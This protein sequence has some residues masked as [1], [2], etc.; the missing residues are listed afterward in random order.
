MPCKIVPAID[1]IDGKCVRL[2]QGSFD[3]VDVVGNDPLE[4]ARSFAA[5]GFSRLH[6]VDLSGA[7]AGSPQHLDVVRTVASQT[8][9]S[10]DYSG[11]LRTNTDIAA[12]LESGAK[13]IVI[14]S[15]AVLSPVLVEEALRSF[16]PDR[17][18]IGLD[19][20][21]GEV[22]IKGW[23]EGSELSLDSVVE[24]YLPCGLKRLMSTS[25]SRDGMLEGPDCEL[26]A[27]LRRRYPTLSLTASGGV[28]QAQDVERLAQLGV[29]EV[30]V[31][32][33]LYSGR[34]TLAE[35]AHYVW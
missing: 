5:Q 31:G 3:A 14:G 29:D 15:A 4:V 6:L 2:K 25:I 27:G 26:Y 23:E 30:I 21:G 1:L 8:S 20:L 28:S 9:L 10:I 32:K 35:V 12:A 19:V 22:R 34:L 7:R 13:A 18:I 17:V 11:G 16:S 33:A 24:R